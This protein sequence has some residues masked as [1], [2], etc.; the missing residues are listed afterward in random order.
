MPL[1][2][3]NNA[4]IVKDGK[5]AENC[6]CCDGWYCYG[7]GC[8]CSDQRPATLSASLSFSLNETAYGQVQTGA[9]GGGAFHQCAKYTSSSFSDVSKTV[10]LSYLGTSLDGAECSYATPLVG[11]Y[12]F[13]SG[14]PVPVG[15][16]YMRAVIQCTATGTSLSITGLHYSARPFRGLNQVYVPNDTFY[17]IK[18]PCGPESYDS[19]LFVVG[20]NAAFVDSPDGRSDRQ[21]VFA[22]PCPNKT[23]ISSPAAKADYTCSS[24]GQFQ[25]E[26]VQWTP[27][28]SSTETYQTVVSPVVVGTLTITA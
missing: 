16:V 13:T 17:A 3:R 15:F 28:S 19:N 4:L 5:L 23:P 2:T 25:Y 12:S 20:L 21:R 24:F 18:A 22:P 9:F 7:G 26:L 11:E 8:G 1:A 10:S 6:E 14:A 27:V